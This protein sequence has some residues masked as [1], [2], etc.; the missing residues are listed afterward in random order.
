MAGAADE[1]SDEL[2]AAAAM[3]S[4]LESH[5]IDGRRPLKWPACV[6][7]ILVT[8]LC[9]RFA[10]YGFTGSLVF[11]FTSLG[12]PSNLAAELNTLFSAVVYVTPVL[13]AYVADVVWG[14][15]RTILFFCS[16]Y[17]VGLVMTT[18][19][20]WPTAGEGFVIPKELA[21]GLSLTGLFLCVSI[22]A[23]G[24]KSN[25]V[26]F[27]AEQFVLPEQTTQQAAFFNFFYWAINLGAT[28]AFLFLSN[29]ALQGLP[30]VGISPR[31]GFFASFCLPTGAF[32]LA[33]LA[34]AL[35]G[36]SYRLRPPQ[37]SAMTGFLATLRKHIWRGR[38]LLL[39]GAGLVLPLA[40]ITVVASFFLPTGHV[41][42]ALAIGGL[43]LIVLALGLLV[44][45]GTS[46]SWLHSPGAVGPEAAAECDAEEI[47]RIL[48]LS[49]CFVAF[50]VIY[51]QMSSNF[52]LQG[53]QMNLLTL[54][55][56]LSPATLQV[57]DSLVIMLLIPLV[58]RGLYPMLD[59]LHL[60]P[61]MLG[62]IGCSN[63]AAWRGAPRTRR[64]AACAPRRLCSR[65]PCGASG[66]APSRRPH[67][68]RCPRTERGRAVEIGRAA[69]VAGAGVE[70]A[71]EGAGRTASTRQLI[72]VAR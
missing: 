57:F 6:L 32:A 67:S 15:Y 13:G 31:F 40:F 47:I 41:R 23:G 25:V 52:Q 22:G 28:G 8:E 51:S 7:L 34:F 38:G 18:A 10:Y 43:L 26:V 53:C 21:L 17:I 48:P 60:K 58:D 24:I 46:T 33:I 36:G 45:S 27:G 14:R 30:S 70:E 4:E 5:L 11:F 59:R 56:K 29:L 44:A 66:G 65:S 35:G 1:L 20:A 37:G 69:E 50:W 12:M 55:T 68:P 39:L 61:S 16:I 72:G 64:S 63:T 49:A 3:A 9:E 71:V 19:G 2:T 42:D 54:G 62:K